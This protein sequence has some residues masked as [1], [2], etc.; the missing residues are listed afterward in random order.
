MKITDEI[1][2]LLQKRAEAA[3]ILA[4][5]DEQVAIKKAEI[6]M[7]LAALSGKV[8]PDKP[9]KA[10]VKRGTVESTV[11]EWVAKGIPDAQLIAENTGLNLGSIRS[12]L[13]KILK[14]GVTVEMPRPDDDD[15]P[16]AGV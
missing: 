11:R 8:E 6:K 7:A 2:E 12:A 10:T 3:T 9:K 13:R 14:S 16:A 5:L 4:D 15:V 1:S